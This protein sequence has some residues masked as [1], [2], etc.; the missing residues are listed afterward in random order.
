MS[1]NLLYGLVLFD[2]DEA[3]LLF[4]MVSLC[5]QIILVLLVSTWL[6]IEAS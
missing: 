2:G 3:K 1:V 4:M 5:F 6:D